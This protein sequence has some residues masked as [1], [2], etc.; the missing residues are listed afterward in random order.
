MKLEYSTV[1]NMQNLTMNNLST[2]QIRAYRHAPSTRKSYEYGRKCLKAW[3]KLPAVVQR[4]A[5][6]LLIDNMDNIILPMEGKVIYDYLTYKT[7]TRKGG[8]ASVSCISGA[9]TVIMDLHTSNGFVVSE[10]IVLGINSI[11]DGYKRVVSELKYS[12]VLP[13]KE[14]KDPLT[15]TGYKSLAKLTVKVTDF[16][17]SIYA[18]LYLLFCWNIG[19]RTHNIATMLYNLLILF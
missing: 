19:A 2:E 6:S 8:H 13:V 15:I 11:L 3:L 5:P 18:H 14:G 7:K 10:D 16:Q 1:P 9:R 17:Q 12:G 4:F